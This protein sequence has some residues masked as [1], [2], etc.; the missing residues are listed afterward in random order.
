MKQCNLAWGHNSIDI[1]SVFC[2]PLL[3][4]RASVPRI[5]SNRK[6]GPEHP[7]IMMLPSCLLRNRRPEQPTGICLVPILLSLSLFCDTQLT[8]FLKS[9]P[10]PCLLGLWTQSEQQQQQC[11][12]YRSSLDEEQQ[13]SHDQSPF[14]EHWGLGLWRLQQQQRKVKKSCRLKGSKCWI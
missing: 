3:P 8:L 5:L 9:L 14:H 11:T 12:T 2:C 10:I 1:S 13:C 4:H 6:L 7:H